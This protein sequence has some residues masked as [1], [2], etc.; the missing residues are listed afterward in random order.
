MGQPRLNVVGPREPRTRMKPKYSPRASCS[1]RYIAIANEEKIIV[2]PNLPDE[3][4]FSC[5]LDWAV[6]LRGVSHV[7][8][9][10]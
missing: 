1:Y 7:H 9:P 3:D 2:P 10:A 5:P 8:N 4:H 6:R